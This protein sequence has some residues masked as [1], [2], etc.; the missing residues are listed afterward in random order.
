MEI[1]RKFTVD[2]EKWSKINKPKPHEIIQGYLLQSA[3]CTIRVR[4]KNEQ[5]FLTLKGKTIG[6]SRSEFEYEIPKQ[7]ALS[8]IEQFTKKTLYK[9]RYE[10][11]IG[12]HIWEVD[13]FK[14]KLAPLILAE[15][16]LKSE[17]EQF[18]KPDWVLQDV[19]LDPQFYNSN[20]IDSIDA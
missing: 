12:D 20:L 18:E 10:I 8:I 17:S 2:I 15:I 3:E 11:K 6:I 4:L 14:G 16:E 13:E 1:E 5:A 9:L 7:D 19:S